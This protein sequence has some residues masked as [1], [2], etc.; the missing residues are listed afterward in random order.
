LPRSRSCPSNLGPVGNHITNQSPE[1]DARN[2]GDARLSDLVEA[3]GVF[4]IGRIEIHLLEKRSDHF[5]RNIWL[6]L[7]KRW[8]RAFWLT[9]AVNVSMPYKPLIPYY[10]RRPSHPDMPRDDI[11]R[12]TEPN[13]AR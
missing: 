8:T 10:D 2:Y 7:A 13:E 3:T 4:E 5:H 11:W 6:S 12:K 9:A 1:F